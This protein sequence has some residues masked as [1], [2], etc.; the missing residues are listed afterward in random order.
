MGRGFCRKE[1]CLD[2]ITLIGLLTAGVCF[3]GGLYWAYRPLLPIRSAFNRELAD[4]RRRF[5]FAIHFIN[6]LSTRWKKEISEVY[7]DRVSAHRR[8]MAIFLLLIVPASNVAAAAVMIFGTCWG[9]R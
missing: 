8:R 7:V 5:R 4:F 9:L 2:L 6:P 3:F 1:L